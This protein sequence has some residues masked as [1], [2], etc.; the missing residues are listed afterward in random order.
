ML[1]AMASLA[2][3][4][5]DSSLRI[6]VGLMVVCFMVSAPLLWLLHFMPS[7]HVATCR[8]PPGGGGGRK[9]QGEGITHPWSGSGSWERKGR[10]AAEVCTSE[11]TEDWGYPLRR[12][13]GAAPLSG[14]SRLYIGA[15]T[16]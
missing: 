13:I 10:S 6:E 14:F 1:A 7:R 12:V 4:R 11:S 3:C 8:T 5:F 2:V 9:A 16:G 15:E